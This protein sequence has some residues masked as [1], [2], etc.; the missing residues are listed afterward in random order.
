VRRMSRVKLTS[1]G[2]RQQ[3]VIDACLDNNDALVMSVIKDMYASVRMESVMIGDDRYI[4]VNQT[5]L[6]E[7]VPIVGSIRTI[8]RIFKKL[9]DKKVLETH[10]EHEMKGVKGTFYFVKPT[11][12][13]DDLTEYV[14]DVNIPRLGK[15]A[16]PVKKG[17]DKMAA[18]GY[19]N[20][21]SQGM[22][23]WRLGV[24]QNDVW[25]TT[26]WRSKDSSTRDSSTKDSTSYDR[27]A[28]IERW[29]EVAP[30]KMRKIV[31]GSPIDKSIKA[32]IADYGLDGLYE[33]IDKIPK[34]S[35]LS[36]KVVNPKTGKLWKMAFS[37]FI[38][39]QNFEKV[40]NGNYPEDEARANDNEFGSG[41]YGQ[42]RV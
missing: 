12:L 36:G 22:T 17:Y 14:P 42:A 15:P 40:Y 31:P 26:N 6:R 39:P 25:G 3:K 9:R 23:K 1:N 29:N 13:L 28:L 35:F 4:W 37:W 21:T 18:G 2:F 27:D 8:Q 24:R 20:L 16:K 32:R 5:Q 30:V 41:G 38:G 19:D 11:K 34:S 7:F 33:A 10:I